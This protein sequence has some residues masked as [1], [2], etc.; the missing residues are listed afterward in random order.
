MGCRTRR[1]Q[2]TRTDSRND[3]GVRPARIRKVLAVGVAQA[4]TIGRVR[5]YFPIFFLL[6]VLKVPVLAMIYLVFWAARPVNEAEAV[7]E[8]GGDDGRPVKRPRTPRGPRRGPRG[9]GGL[10]IPVPHEGRVRRPSG[11]PDRTRPRERSI[12]RDTER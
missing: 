12:S 4:G 3:D 1:A 8:D 9:P 11:Q 5:E 10:T 2:L 6:V 7:D